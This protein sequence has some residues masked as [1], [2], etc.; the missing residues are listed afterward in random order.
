MGRSTDDDK[1]IE[2]NHLV[3]FGSPS[4]SC[5]MSFEIT[6]FNNVMFNRDDVLTKVVQNIDL[7]HIRQ[8]SRNDEYSEYDIDVNETIT[9]MNQLLL[10]Q[11][12]LTP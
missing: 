8:P 5:I 7:D 12:I 10:I 2:L 4:T 11:M 1:D 9:M 6:D 3:N